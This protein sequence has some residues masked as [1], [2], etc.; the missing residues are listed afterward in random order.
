[1][2]KYAII[3]AGGLGIRMGGDIPKQFQ[4]LKGKPVLWHSIK[5]FVNAYDDIEIIVVLPT[6]HIQKGEE[7][8]K[9]FSSRFIQITTGGDTR[10]HSVKNGLKL[11]KKESIVFVHDAVRCLVTTDLIHRCYEQASEKGSAIPVIKSKDSLRMTEG[12]RMV[13]LDRNKVMLVQTPQTFQSKILLSAYKIEYNE[14]FTDEATVVENSGQKVSVIEGEE[15][16]I[17]ITNP[18]DL[19]IAEQIFGVRNRKSDI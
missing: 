3:V 14:K 5:A 15:D 2:Y 6:A 9:G 1:M 11:V 4:L 10:F 7:L 19:L 13:S 16:N 17:K 12:E 18:I 8:L